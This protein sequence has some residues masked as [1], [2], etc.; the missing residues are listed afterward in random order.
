MPSTIKPGNPLYLSEGKMKDVVIR[1]GEGDKEAKKTLKRVETGVKV[2]SNARITV[3]KAMRGEAPKTSREKKAVRAALDKSPSKQK[4]VPLDVAADVYE[5][6]RDDGS[7]YDPKTGK[8]RPVTVK[9][10]KWID[11]NPKKFRLVKGPSKP[12]SELSRGYDENLKWK[13]V[14]S[15]AT[16]DRGR[17]IPGSSAPN[18]SKKTIGKFKS[19][20]GAGPGQ[21]ERNAKAKEE[22]EAKTAPGG[23]NEARGIVG[24]WDRP[25]QRYSA[26]RKKDFTPPTPE[27]VEKERNRRLE[28]GLNA[29]GSKKTVTE[30]NYSAMP[31]QKLGPG[32]VERNKHAATLRLVR[33]KG[34]KSAIAD[35]NQAVQG[36]SKNRKNPLNTVSVDDAAASHK[37]REQHESIEHQISHLNTSTPAGAAKAK[38]LKIRANAQRLDA[39]D[40]AVGKRQGHKVDSKG[41]PLKGQRVRPASVAAARAAQKKQDL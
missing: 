25:S 20:P 29:D 13:P 33:K 6:K 4:K 10:G 18:K 27:E 23:T 34:L 28:A 40:A 3:K 1:A 22:A 15:E 12:A 9:K 41:R 38:E 35:P 5:D 31:R 26:N 24:K 14:V 7:M 37:R 21:A 11:N 30:K 17:T 32:R 2:E 36:V 19:Q 8:R 39:E 16:D